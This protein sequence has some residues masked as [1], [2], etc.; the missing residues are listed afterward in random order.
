MVKM[1]LLRVL[2]NRNHLFLSRLKG[3]YCVVSGSSTELLYKIKFQKK[4]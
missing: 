3:Q 4:A 1:L 2:W